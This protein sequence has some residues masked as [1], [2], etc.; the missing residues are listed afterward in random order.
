[1][2]IIAV[3]TLLSFNILSSAQ[4]NTYL[5]DLEA[6]RS[7]LQK[8]PSYKAQI[9]GEQL[10]EYN[11]LYQQLAI[12]T[13]SDPIDYKYFFNL[14]QLIFPLRDNHIGFYQHANYNNFTNKESVDRYIA[15]TEFSKHP[16]IDIN[17]DSMKLSLSLKPADSPKNFIMFA[18]EKYRHE[19]LVNSFFYNSY[20]QQRYSKK[21]QNVDYINLP[22]NAPDFE[23]SSINNNIQYIRIG[24]FQRNTSITQKSRDLYDSILHNLITSNL[25]I[26]LRNQEGGAAIE[27]KKYLNLFQKFTKKGKLYLLVNN[28]TL[29]QAEM[30]IL[31]LKK[32]NNVVV[33]GETTQGKLTYGSNYGNWQKLPSGKFEVYPT[34][35]KGKK[36]HLIYEDYGIVPDITLNDD[37][38]WI[39]QLVSIIN[40]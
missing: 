21:V 25:I 30:F 3:L 26:D 20:S 39:D 11:R 23:F 4:T 22:A 31:K 14:S 19:T 12:D 24:S 9:T 37:S 15:S 28:E 36:E 34:D 7:I 38:D 27:A 13:I 35:M 16:R 17:I 1:M 29:S 32:S 2:R 8:T 5:K 33:V 40:K 18:N 10:T 6:L